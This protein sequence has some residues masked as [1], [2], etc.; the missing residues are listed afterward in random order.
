MAVSLLLRGGRIRALKAALLEA[1]VFRGELASTV[2]LSTESENNKKAAG[3]TSKTE[4]VFKDVVG[5]EERAKLLDTHT[6]AALSKSSPPP[7]SYPSVE[8]TGGAVAGLP[9]TD[10]SR[11][12]LVAFPQ[13][14]TPPPHAWASDSEA[15]RHVQ[16][17][18]KDSSSSSSSS[19]SDSDSD[20]EEHGSDIGPRVAS[21]S[22]A[23]FSKPEASRPSKNGAPKITVFAKEKA[24]VQKPHTDVTYPEKPLQPKKKGTFTKPVED[25]KETRSKLMTSKPQS[26]EVLEQKMKEKQ[27]QGKRRPDKTGKESTELFEAEGILPGHRK[28]RVSTQPT[29]GTQEASAELRPAAAPESGARQEAKGPELEWKTASPLV[30]KES[31]EKQVPEGSFQ[32]EEETSGDQTLGRYSK[33][34]PVEE[35]NTFGE[36]AGP[37]LEGTFQA[38]AGEAPPTDAGPPQEAPGDTQEPTLVPESSDTTTYKNLQHHEYNAFT[39]LDLNLD[40]SKFRLP[41]P[42]SGRESPRH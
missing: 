11:K 28:A 41:Q 24:K 1:K 40:L 16:K 25:S 6:A 39:F 42:S 34:V 30:R 15:R 22:K 13:K 20:G 38:P 33:T 12:T 8:N 17:V 9:L 7:S 36:R 10:L 26:S 19:S 5:A 37:Q 18:T 35:K 14:V 32:A 21:K 4:S 29:T 2:P 3:P 27:H 31:L 23:G